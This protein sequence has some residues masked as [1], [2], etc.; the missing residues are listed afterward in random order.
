MSRRTPTQL[1]DA[2]VARLRDEIG[3]TSGT[4]TS[5]KYGLAKTWESAWA[6]GVEWQG[7]YCNRFA[8]WGADQVL[9]AEAARAA[10]GRQAGVPIPAGFAATWL[11]REW[12][13]ANGRHVGFANSQPGDHYLFKL[14]GR[15]LNPTNHIGVFVRWHVVGKVAVV[16]EANLPRP[17]HGASTIGVWEH[18]R[19][20]TY[21]VGVYRPDWDAAAEVYNARFPE[22][23]P[24]PKPKPTPEPE[25]ARPDSTVRAVQQHLTVLG[26]QPG[27]VD[28][29]PGPTTTAAVRG[30]QA[31]FG[32]PTTGVPDATT[33]TSLEDTM[34]KLDDLITE[35]KALRKEVNQVAWNTRSVPLSES[36]RKILGT[37]HPKLSPAGLQ[38]LVAVTV[39]AMQKKVATSADVDRVI[40]AI[41]D[42]Q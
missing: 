22:P 26:Y 28:G 12:H 35:V 34:S 14:P 13:M 5:S 27:P 24:E 2:V 16:V 11:Q 19:D 18:L 41:K 40:A 39:R 37:P 25:P 33:L 7:M 21:V 42:D 30:Y 15:P 1:R 8:S 20:I 9:G 10:I 4:Y 6:W 29:L 17:G 3:Y 31:D 23:A 32:H 36:D 38:K